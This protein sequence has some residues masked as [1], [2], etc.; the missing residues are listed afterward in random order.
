MQLVRTKSLLAGGQQI[1]TLQP[2]SH[3]NVAVLENGADLDCELVTAGIAFIGANPSALSLHLRNAFD[4]TAMRANGTVWP[5]DA[6]DEIVCLLFIVQIGIGQNGH[7]NLQNWFQYTRSKWVRQVKYTLQKGQQN[8]KIEPI[9]IPHD[10]W[11]MS[12]KSRSTF[13]I[14]TCSNSLDLGSSPS[15]T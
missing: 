13:S 15:I 14:R 12:R 5:K 2:A 9:V 10:Q 8:S 11:S 1:D 3:R 6:F 4:R 7:R